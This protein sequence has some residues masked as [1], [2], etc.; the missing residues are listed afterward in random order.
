MSA[1]FKLK[2][3]WT[4]C[5]EVS[6]FQESILEGFHYILYSR[7]ILH[8]MVPCLLSLDIIQSSSYTQFA[9]TEFIIYILN[10]TCTCPCEI[11]KLRSCKLDNKRLSMIDFHALDS[12]IGGFRMVTNLRGDKR[13]KDKLYRTTHKS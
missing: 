8:N 9:Y 7:A 11:F 10:Y 2:V 3:C 5:V 13:N 12:S 4:T 1:D 6:L